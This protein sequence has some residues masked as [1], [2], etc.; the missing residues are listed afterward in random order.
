[1]TTTTARTTATTNIII[2][3]TTTATTTSAATITTATTTT[4]TTTT[5]TTSSS[6]YCYG[7]QASRY[8]LYDSYCHCCVYH[9]VYDYVHYELDEHCDHR[10]YPCYRYN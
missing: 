10:F 2:T 3:T 1:M 7:Y 8:H 6:H 5:S 4:T 9:D